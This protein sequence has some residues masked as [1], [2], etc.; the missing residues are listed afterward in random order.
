MVTF[1]V[2]LKAL[3]LLVASALVFVLWVKRDNGRYSYHSADS[4][5]VVHDTRTGTLF[6][7]TNAELNGKGVWV[8]I[9]PQGGSF[10]IRNAHP[11]K[12]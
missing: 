11:S 12:P 4:G 1:D 6:V 8:E 7:G 10:T 9:H 5:V 3:A 2:M